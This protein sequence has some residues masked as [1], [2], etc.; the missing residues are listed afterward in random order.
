[1]D[2]KVWLSDNPHKV[3]ISYEENKETYDSS[4]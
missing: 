3:E 4:N 2:E 1:M